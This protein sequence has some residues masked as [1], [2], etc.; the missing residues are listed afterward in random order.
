M[1]KT[2]I[3]AAVWSTDADP[4]NVRRVLGKVAG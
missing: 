4:D 1:V 3:H 2:A